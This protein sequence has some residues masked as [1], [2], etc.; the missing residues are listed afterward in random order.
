MPDAIEGRG[1]FGTG[2]ESGAGG[3]ADGEIPALTHGWVGLD[4][5]DTTENV[6]ASATADG[7][8]GLFI[9]QD[10]TQRV[11]IDDWHA[12]SVFLY[13]FRVG[14]DDEVYR[15]AHGGTGSQYGLA[16]DQR[17]TPA[18]KQ[19]W[20]TFSGEGDI[21]SWGSVSGFNANNRVNIANG[22]GLGGLASPHHAEANPPTQCIHP[23][24]ANANRPVGEGVCPRWM[25]QVKSGGVASNRRRLIHQPRPWHIDSPVLDAG[26]VASR[27]A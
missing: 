9:A 7:G 23:V 27:V 16:G 22:D 17:V 21:K 15:I 25:H 10:E 1:E 26:C 2:A 11:V 13:Q 18:N 24:L 5:D 19:Q 4:G 8:G 14:T 3:E 12:N 6:T 20:V